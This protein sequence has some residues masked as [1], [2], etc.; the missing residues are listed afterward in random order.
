M[1]GGLISVFLSFFSFN[2]FL[3]QRERSQGD[4]D[5]MTLSLATTINDKDR[6][7][8]IN[9]MEACSRELV[10]TS[11][12]RVHECSRQDMEDLTPLCDQLLT[13]AREG[14]R[15]VENERLNQIKL[16]CL[17]L[18]DRAQR[19]N[20][21]AEGKGGFSL[22]WLRTK[23]PV[24]KK[25]EIGSI[26]RVE[27]NVKRNQGLPDLHEYDLQ[28]GFLNEKSKLIR[29]NVNAKL[30]DVDGDLDFHIAGLPAS[31]NGTSSPARS[32][33]PEVFVPAAVIF[34]NGK[35]LQGTVKQIPSAIQ[36]TTGMETS[37][38]ENNS[39]SGSVHIISTGAASGARAGDEF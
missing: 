8:Q 21:D 18:Q 39:H 29:S 2:G 19:H 4:V 27:S 5:A 32:V 35:L 22:A 23:N 28:H 7:G 36:I 33:N 16:I 25:I 13:E 1:L 11:R 26:A 20:Q 38:G 34:E 6:V 30:P 24:V 9:E 10:Y 14:H 31:V 15:L 17:E 12:R 3:M 37:V